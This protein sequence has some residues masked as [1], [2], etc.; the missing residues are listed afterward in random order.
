MKRTLHLFVKHEF[1]FY[2]LFSPAEF[3]RFVYLSYN[4]YHQTE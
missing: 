3:V 2:A 1:M 4:Q